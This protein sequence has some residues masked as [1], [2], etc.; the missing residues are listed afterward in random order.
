MQQQ[1]NKRRRKITRNYRNNKRK[2]TFY[3]DKRNTDY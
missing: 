2:I 1:K 3:F